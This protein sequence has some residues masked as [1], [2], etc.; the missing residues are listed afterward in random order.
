MG[1]GSFDRMDLASPVL[2]QR[3]RHQD[4]CSSLLQTHGEGYL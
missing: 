2:V 4:V 1:S 3:E